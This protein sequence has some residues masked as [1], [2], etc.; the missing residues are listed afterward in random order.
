[1]SSR[2]NSP[3][4]SPTEGGGTTSFPVPAYLNFTPGGLSYKK[5]S[6]DLSNHWYDLASYS[7]NSAPSSS[8]TSP[9]RRKT[10]DDVIIKAKR[11][12][13]VLRQYT[14]LYAQSMEAP[15]F[16]PSLSVLAAAAFDRLSG[17]PPSAAKRWADAMVLH[18]LEPTEHEAPPHSEQSCWTNAGA[19]AKHN[20]AVTNDSV[21]S[22]L[23]QLLQ[24]ST[25][26]GNP[27][28]APRPCGYVFKRGDIAWNCRTCQTDPTCVIC[29]TCFRN[30]NHDGHEVYFHRTTPGGCCDCGDAEAWKSSGCCPLHKHIQDDSVNENDPEE[31]VMMALRG[32]KQGMD[33]LQEPPTKLPAKLAAALGVVIGAAVQALVQAVDGAGIGADPIQWKLRWTDEACRIRNG[34]V[35]RDDYYLGPENSIL[36]TPQSLLQK[37]NAMPKDYKL[38][39]RLHNDDVHTFD[40]VIEALHEPRHNRR[41]T[42][43]APL[44]PLVANRDDADEMTHH[45]DADGQVT[46][47]SYQSIALAMQGYRRLK[48]KQRGLHCAVVGT[49]VVDAEHRARALTLWLSEISAAHPAAAVLVVHALVQLDHDMA[50]IEVW[51]EAKCIP[52]WSSLL[53]GEDD[54]TTCRRRFFAFPPHLASSYVTRE[55]AEALHGLGLEMNAT[56]FSEMTGTDPNFYAN[57]PYRLPSERYRKSPHALWGTLP[58]TYSDGI[59]LANKHPLLYRLATGQFDEVAATMKTQLVE[60]IYVVDTDLRKQEESERILASMYSHKLPG[61]HMISGIGT[62]RA[63]DITVAAPPVP[64]PMQWRHLLQTC[65]FRAPVTPVALMLLLDPYP[66]KQV[67]SGL[68]SL[69]LSLL[70]DSRFKCRF[71][72]ALGAVAYRP[73]STLF[74]AGVGTESD[75]PLG[76]TVQIFTAGSLVRALGNATA[77]EKLLKSD[78]AGSD[79]ENGAPIGVFAMPLAHNIVRCIHTNLLGATKEVHMI[80]K[81]TITENDDDSH[82]ED[83]RRNDS[84]LPTLTY[85]AGEHPLSVPLPG[86]PD[87]GYLDSRSTRHKRL[88]H[89]LRDLEYVVETPGTAI[90]LLLPHKYPMYQKVK[91]SSSTSSPIVENAI[92]FAAVYARLLRTSQGVEYEKSRW[93]DAFGLSLNFAG[94]RDALAE[95]LTNASSSTL[96]P[97]SDDG[98]HLVNIQEAMGCLFTALLKELKLWLYREGMLETGLPLPPTGSHG[99]MDAS[100]VEAL[101]RSTLHVSSSQLGAVAAAS[102]PDSSSGGGGNVVSVA[103]ACATGVKMTEAQLELIEGALR[104]EDAQRQHRSGAIDDTIPSSGPPMGDWLRI[105]HSPLGGD[106]LSFHLPLHRALAKSVL[107]ICYVVVPPSVRDSNPR[108]WWKLPVLDNNYDSG[109]HSVTG[110]QHPLVALIRSSLRS[111]N[112]RV[113]WTAGPD[114]SSAEAQQRRSRS[115]NVSANIAAAKI[116]HSLADHPLR[117]LAAA[118]QIERHLWARNGTS[119][120]GMALNYA[121]SPLCRSFRDLDITLVQLSSSGMSMGLGARRVFSLLMSRF[122]MDGYLCDPER[123]V[124]G[125]SSPTSSGAY[126]GGGGWVNP[127]RMQD[128]E[129]A[130]ALSESFF[131]T[132]CIVVTELPPPPPLTP[133]DD[134]ALRHSLRRELLHA[135]AAEPRSHSEAMEAATSAA[136]RR[137]ESAG[138]SGG[139]SAGGS[140]GDV[141]TQVL[142]EVGMQKTQGSSRAASGPSA[143]ELRPECSNE[144]DPTFFHLRRQDHQHAMDT[145]ARLRKQKAGKEAESTCYPVV[146]SPPLA[147]PRFVSCRLLLHLQ[148]MDAA[149]RRSLLFAVTGGAWLPPNEPAPPPIEKE[150]DPMHAESLESTTTMT[151]GS[152]STGDGGTVQVTTF[153]RRTHHRAGSSAGSSRRSSEA[154][155]LTPFSPAVVAGSSVSYLEVLQLLTLQVHTLEECASLHRLQP[156][157]DEEARVLSASLSINSYLGRLTFVPESLADVWAFRPYPE[158]PLPSKGSGEDRGSILGLLIMLYEHRADPGS[159]EKSGHGE[160]AGGDEGQGG[161]RTLSNSGLKW[162][163]R[164]VN[165]LV[166]GA[167]SV[168]AAAK[169]ATTGIPVPTGGGLAESGST[170]W[171]INSNIRTKIGGM[172]ASLPDL[173]PKDESAAV[174]EDADRFN[175]KSKEARKAAQQRVMDMMK[176]KQSAFAATIA[177]S[178]DKTEGKMEV[179]ENEAD[180]CIICRC[181]DADGENNGPL[182]YLG[183]VQRSRYA[184]MR[185]CTE[186]SKADALY[187]TYRVAGHR[188]CQLRKTE[189][190]DSEPL[191]CLPTG[192]VVTVVSSTVCDAYDILSRRVFVHHEATDPDSGLTTETEGWASV[193]SSEGYVILS[194]LASLC[195][196]NTRWGNT[197]PIIRQ[198]GHAAHLKCV[199]THTLSLHQ[200]AAGEQPYD[201][202]FAANIADGEFL[203]PLCKQLSN[204]LIPRDGCALNAH[205]IMSESQETNTMTMGVQPDELPSL[206]NRLTQKSKTKSDDFSQ[207]G[208]EALRQFGSRLSQAMTV[209]WE[210][211]TAAKKKKQRRW[212]PS[213]HRWDFEDIDQPV[214]EWADGT[215]VNGAPVKDVL[216]RLRQLHIAWAAIG[217]SAASVECASRSL[218]EVLP[219]GTFAQTSDPWNDFNEESQDSHPMLLELRRSLTATSGF[220]EVLVEQLDV[221]FNAEGKTPDTVSHF[222]GSCLADILRGNCKFATAK[223]EQSVRSK[224]ALAIWS[225]AT[226]LMAAMPCHVSRDGTLSQR[227]EARA[228]ASAMWVVNGLGTENRTEPPPVDQS[229][230]DVSF[231]DAPVPLAI[232]QVNLLTGS[233]MPLNWGT[234]CSS[235][236][237]EPKEIDSPFRPGVASS[238]L[239]L[240]LMAW[241]FYTFSGAVFSAMLTTGDGKLPSSIELISAAKLLLVGRVIQAIIT[242]AGYELCDEDDEYEYDEFWSEEEIVKES[243]ALS[244][245]ILFCKSAVQSRSINPEGNFESKLEGNEAIKHFSAVGRAILPFARSL[246]LILRATTSAIRD[247]GKKGKQDTEKQTATDKQLDAALVHDELLTFEDGFLM[248]K[249]LGIP[250]PSVIIDQS[251]TNIWV[252]LIKRWIGAAM[253]L[254]LHHG[255]RGKSLIP[256]FS[257]ESIHPSGKLSP[258]PKKAPRIH[259]E[260]EGRRSAGMG[261]DDEDDDE[262]EHPEHFF[263]GMNENAGVADTHMGAMVE[264]EMMDEMD[265]AEEEMDVIDTGRHSAGT[266]AIDDSS[267]EESFSNALD[268]K[269]L[270]FACVSRSAIIPYQPSLLRLEEIGPGTRGA[271]LE[272]GAASKVMR[273]MSHLGMIHRK[274]MATK[275]LVRL[276]KSFVELYSL[277]NKVKGRDDAAAMDVDD[278]GGS[279]ETAICLLTGSVMRSGSPRRS[280]VRTSRPP[281]ACTLHS[282]QVGSGIGIFFLVQKCTVLLMHNNKSAYSASLY[283]DQHGEEDPGLRRGRPLFLN[284]ARYRALEVLWRQQGIP[285]EVAQ[286]RSTSDRVIRDNWY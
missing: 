154:L 167:P 32:Q 153:G 133:S 185:S 241:D 42:E 120:A 284:E 57:V 43:D 205:K 84:L 230:A 31:A 213:I 150:E 264:D 283:V 238:F 70:V 132:M 7:M 109:D 50:G 123:R 207:I 249:E 127:P 257:P 30:S 219:F 192:S 71:A 269:Q 46:V 141:F 191:V 111:S 129:H 11:A 260:E 35:N 47:K 94:T 19:N 255:S 54:L 102:T 274:N 53:P 76:F 184:Q 246:V 282:R 253:E 2:S 95:S 9:R 136:S 101:Q 8:S 157:L 239:Y 106:H 29:D 277:V 162:L 97:Y 171:T 103:L 90:R 263:R 176:K 172:L 195:Y 96:A 20:P 177:P 203:C 210:R 163:L 256:M 104:L 68:H 124:Q 107:S 156:D 39:L 138:I 194:P 44:P 88:P 87:D 64:N 273:D 63:Q 155:D 61:V 196:T 74:C 158:G 28:S 140:L 62:L 40:E 200:R 139:N 23:R 262:D 179:D 248:F 159:E 188:G 146:S 174:D 98:S 38:H 4:S 197:R 14:L 108:G 166:D 215:N 86:A 152:V 165:A 266:D 160:S 168:A 60:E 204:I 151:T 116:I 48:G 18:Y 220:Y 198:C 56:T 217:H 245:L 115:K 114:C 112:C 173:W 117:C 92:A 137:D 252:P 16:L 271:P 214:I 276:P 232:K 59:A 161:S 275:C 142:R 99:G 216:R 121:S 180:L 3:P 209:P 125:P 83:P 223:F 51:H 265:M 134:L 67:R 193:Q 130:V 145:V 228:T 225:Q 211:A 135:L 235:I 229:G 15:H 202:R 243:T 82:E 261:M 278:D 234:M 181:D 212:H 280:Y 286:I 13:D 281:G 267:D 233:T 80:L 69:F 52:T 118:Q 250:L 244:K 259:T 78:H 49:S 236:V 222:L 144:Y 119:T 81:N 131:T 73:L 93:L 178:D 34:A 201:G 33:T 55:E 79:S 164:F 75:T 22:V 149:L 1:M 175:A 182:G 190:M 128:T 227:H 224:S 17:V 251:G 226:A 148:S 169:S 270:D 285:R 147:H 254:E 25:A 85:Q 189:A 110:N 221:M 258:V 187:L 24:T 66:T 113:V 26:L 37:G 279:S 27:P 126:G 206:H 242:P 247:R 21:A 105:P 89:L 100:L 65:S 186:A 240:P 199:E 91:N 268:D 72:A 45:V 272:C 36:E 5:S 6:A 58:S 41:A 122:N 218:E 170:S 12:D 143:Y 231:A 183:H 10:P 237:M 208:Q 77:T